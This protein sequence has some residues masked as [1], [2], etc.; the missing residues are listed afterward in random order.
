MET[1]WRDKYLKYKI[2]YNQLKKLIGSAKNID[3]NKK[4]V[5]SI[6]VS[7]NGRL[8]CL[9]NLFQDGL[10]DVGFQ[11]CAILKLVLNKE[12]CEL[13][14]I[15]SG[16][17]VENYKN[18][19]LNNSSNIIGGG[20]K[21]YIVPDDK[22]I[23]SS[24]ILFNPISNPDMLKIL[25]IK[26]ED[27]EDKE[28]IFYLIRHGDGIHNK[29]KAEGKKGLINPSLLD[30]ELTL[31]GKNQ[32]KQAGIFLKSFLQNTSI[33][34]LFASDL[35]RTIQTLEGVLSQG[36]ILTNPKQNVVILPC[37]HELDKIGTNCDKN[38]LNILSY[39]NKM[40]C[41]TN[42]PC[43]PTSKTTDYCSSIIKSATD[44]SLCLNWN[45]YNLFYD[46]K[47]RSNMAFGS[48]RFHCRDTSMLS[49]GLFA[50]SNPNCSDRLIMEKWIK[51]R[52]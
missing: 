16:S 19:N 36:I 25:K 39:E 17:L 10:G 6:I 43:N 13:S 22:N 52:K 21:H 50:I 33:D 8:R 20:E 30:A 34:N 32:A 45:F 41:E 3:I 26:P 2:K 46:G 4:Q 37:S 35:K 24:G 14:L 1:E 49:M 7:H 40:N 48:K 42:L 47:S 9:I 23:K 29:A 28:Y 18:S 27:L 38:Q 31:E 12:S 51:D 11:N 15:Y 5:N 44:G